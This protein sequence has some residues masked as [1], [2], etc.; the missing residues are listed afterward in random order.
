MLFG[1]RLI[2]WM[3]GAEALTGYAARL[4]RE[5]RTRRWEDCAATLPDLL[6]EAKKIRAAMNPQERSTTTN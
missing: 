3:V 5:A 1:W 2:A 4:E 6:A